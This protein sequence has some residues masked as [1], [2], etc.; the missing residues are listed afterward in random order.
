MARRHLPTVWRAEVQPDG[1]TETRCGRYV[2]PGQIADGADVEGLDVVTAEGWESAGRLY[3]RAC[4]R[5]HRY[6]GQ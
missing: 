2:P 5:E 3:C 4:L 6:A 1:R